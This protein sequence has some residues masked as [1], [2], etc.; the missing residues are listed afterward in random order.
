MTGSSYAPQYYPSGDDLSRA[1]SW[2]VRAGDELAGIDFTLLPIRTFRVSG[3]VYDAVNGRPGV[4]AI[5][6]LMPRNRD[7]QSISPTSESSALDPHGAFD[8]HGVT[9]GTYYLYAAS[10]EAD[11]QYIARES[12]T[13]A[14]ADLNNLRLLIGPGIDL[15]GHIRVEGSAAL[16]MNTLNIS[17]RARDGAIDMGEAASS[18][19][20]DASF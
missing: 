17:L 9:P 7:V 16:D 6:W 5:V 13:V 18:I 1:I 14:D 4:H 2:N 11:K 12:I 3:N 8:L 10:T 20:P 15:R 19:K